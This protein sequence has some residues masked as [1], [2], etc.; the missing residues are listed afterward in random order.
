MNKIIITNY[1]RIEATN[2]HAIFVKFS[3][4]YLAHTILLF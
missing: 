4:L 2:A 3:I 1:M